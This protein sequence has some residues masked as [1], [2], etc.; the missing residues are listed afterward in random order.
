[1]RGIVAAVG[2][3][4]VVGLADGWLA[5]AAANAGCAFLREGFADRATRKDGSLVPRGEPGAIVD[6]P[7]DALARVQCLTTEGAV[8]T[9]CVHGD[10]PH[11]VPIARAV[12]RFLG[13]K[14]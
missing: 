13:P 1:M 7:N 3:V 8:D 12:R 2:N 5:K 14:E 6:D 11:A 4:A 10:T 9:V